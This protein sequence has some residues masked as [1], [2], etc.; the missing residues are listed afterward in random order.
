MGCEG[1]EVTSDD[2]EMLEQLECICSYPPRFRLKFKPEKSAN[3]IRSHNV[4]VTF[5]DVTPPTTATITLPGICCN[6]DYNHNTDYHMCRQWPS[7]FALKSSFNTRNIYRIL[8]KRYEHI[9]CI[10]Y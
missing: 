3:N 7:F 1:G 4:T 8:L 6:V 2:I 9:I 10:S 5:N